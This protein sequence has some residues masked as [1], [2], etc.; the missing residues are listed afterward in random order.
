M[1]TYPVAHLVALALFDKAFALPSL[2]DAESVFSPTALVDK[3]L[4][5][6]W[7]P[8]ILNVPILRESTERTCSVELSGSVALSRLSTLCRN[9]GFQETITWYCFRCLN[10]S[11]RLFRVS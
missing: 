2:C 1:L 6:T 10:V 3:K 4:P 7:R 8:D 11:G 9:M 5:L